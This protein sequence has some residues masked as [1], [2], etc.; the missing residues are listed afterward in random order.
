MLENTKGLVLRTRRLT[1]T[2]LIVNWLTPDSGRISTVAK[3]ALR[4]KSSFRGKLDLFFLAEFAFARSRRSDL[5]T[6]R[7]MTLLETHPFLRT[8]L[9]ALRQASYCAALLEQTT[10]TDTPLPGMFEMMLGYLSSCSNTSDPAFVTNPQRVFAF[11]LRLLN[12]LGL[13]PDFEKSRVSMETRR[14]VDQ[15]LEADWTV[16]PDLKPTPAQAVEL[17]RFLHGFLIFHFGKL[18]RGRDAALA[19]TYQA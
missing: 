18:A 12:E 6:L 7:E 14:L 13:E 9:Q 16:L 1:E 8:E 4:P 5:H 15:L 11:E 10:E 19:G 17:R 2:S 3:G